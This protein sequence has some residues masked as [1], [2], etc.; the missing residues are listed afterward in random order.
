ME[1]M[2]RNEV[3]QAVVDVLLWWKIS[4]TETNI[5]IQ[6]HCMHIATLRKKKQGRESRQILTV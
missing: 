4:N 3:Y 6:K 2:E 1:K 5:F